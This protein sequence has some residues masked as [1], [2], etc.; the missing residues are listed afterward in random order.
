MNT[1]Q[2]EVN[3]DKTELHTKRAN[4]FSV[5]NAPSEEFYH[6]G[7]LNYYRTDDPRRGVMQ[8][9]KD[10]ATTRLYEGCL[11]PDRVTFKQYY[12]MYSRNNVAARVIETFPNYTWNVS[13]FIS[14]AGGPQSRFSKKANEL[15]HSE[16]STKDNLKQS[17]LASMK[18]LDI[19]GGIGGEALLVLGFADNRSLSSQVTYKKDMQLEYVTIL[20]NGQFK[21][22]KWNEDKKS[23]YYGNIETYITQD[24]TT[25]GEINFVNTIAPNTKIHHTRCVHFKE[26][27]GLGYGT[28]RIQKCYNQLLD[29]VKV[30][31]ASAEVYWLG[32][33]SGMSVELLPDVQL[34]ESTREN[35]ERA[36]RKY[37]NGLAR[38][39]LFEGGKAKLL[40]PAIVSPKEHF[41]L[42]I[43]MVSIASE[44]P[45][46]FL[47]GA[48][49]AKLAS[50]QDSINWMERVGNRRTQFIGPKVVS[51][52]IQRCVNAGVLPK[53]KGGS[54]KVTWPQ[55]QVLPLNE[56]AES[57][58]LMTEAI[59]LYFTNNIHK[60][61]ALQDYLVGICGYGEEEA[62]VIS[63]KVNVSRYKA[64]EKKVVSTSSSGTSTEGSDE[65]DEEEDD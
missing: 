49:A 14:D 19:L 33:F 65:E 6:E 16:V 57:A 48:E 44:I 11:Y 38:S 53:P 36:I 45:R 51:P 13:P 20:H 46:R 5:D 26:S 24:F 50:Q 61:M 10:A 43:S 59:S 52:F 7:P 32:A 22:D 12:D 27:S 62:R 42:Q 54:I 37:F 1:K 2:K 63:D 34:D 18:Q 39:L 56:R 3:K 35:M 29:I 47:I 41:D 31:G 15:L 60:V 17:I 9:N 4:V 40:Y 25:S 21:I 23:R 64:P 58:K 28:S 55:T 8:T 30:S